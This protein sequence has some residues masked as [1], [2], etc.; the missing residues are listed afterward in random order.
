MSA[1]DLWQLKIPI[2]L[3][4]AQD[5]I[6]SPG[7]VKPVYLLAPR[8]AY[9]PALAQQCLSFFQHVLLQMPGQ[10][11]DKPVPWF[12]YEGLA[13]NWTQPLGVLHDLLTPRCTHW[14]SQQQQQQHRQQSCL[15]VST[16][17]I[18]WCLTVHFRNSPASLDSSWQ[19]SGTAQ[20]HFLSSLKEAGYCCRGTDGCNAVMRLTVQDELWAAV[21]RGDGAVVR[22]H[23][24][25]LRL[26]PTQRQGSVVPTVPVRLFIRQHK[27]DSTA[28]L[29]GVWS[30]VCSS[31]R[32]VEVQQPDGSATLLAHLAHLVMPQR[33]PAL[34]QQQQQLD[35][36]AGSSGVQQQE[37]AGQLAAAANPL[38]V[39][40]PSTQPAAAGTAAGS[41]SSS[42]SPAAAA[43]G[44]ATVLPQQWPASC[45]A[46]YVCGVQ[47]D[48]CTPL[49]W[50]HEHM[51]AADGFL[52]V[53]VHLSA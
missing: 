6:S 20:D 52:Y 23:L 24:A 45:S 32:A 47:P 4:L 30:D 17:A 10:D 18:P 40:T 27:A 5:E 9:L 2:R 31:T 15:V 12:E 48:W 53:A 41:S 51:K 11:K 49:G 43:A 1:Q 7:D 46:V 14:P 29:I 35:T 38:G 26:T 50:L 22:Q 39:L 25:P 21:N 16:G 36:A 33:F 19:N 37:V 3:T 44:D 42:L 13:L 28:G 8:F 34:V